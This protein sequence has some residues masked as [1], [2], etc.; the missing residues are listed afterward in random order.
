MT[1]INTLRHHVVESNAIEHIGASVGEPLY[2]RHLDAA[3]F[4]DGRAK[5]S[6]L[7]MPTEVGGVLLP[8]HASSYRTGDVTVSGRMMPSPNRVPLLM[9]KWVSAWARLDAFLPHKPDAT[10]HL[11]VKNRAWQ[12]HH[13]FLCIHPFVD[14][15]GRT[16]RLL[17]NSFL[18]RGGAKW[19]IVRHSEAQDYYATIRIFE[20]E[21]FRGWYPATRT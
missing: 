6:S 15:N 14:G 21:V 10:W 8:S 9:E 3:K 18:V 11:W 2:D 17:L 12:F 5:H 1:H 19:H 20:D 16:S 13:S 4:V 7:A